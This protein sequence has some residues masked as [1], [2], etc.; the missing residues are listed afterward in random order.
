MPRPQTYEDLQQRID[1]LEREIR[2][3]GRSETSLRQSR[4][5]L[6]RFTGNM[7]ESLMVIDTDFVI[8]DVNGRFLEE[9]GGIPEEVL[10]QACHEITQCMENPC[11]QAGV[12]CP[13]KETFVS[14]ETKRMERIDQAADGKEWTQELLAFPLFGEEGNVDHVVVVNH[15]ITDRKREKQESIERE[16]LEGVLEM[17]G[18]VCLEL[19]Q[20]LQALSLYCERLEKAISEDNLLYDQIRWIVDKIDKM[21]DITRKLQSIATYQTK[22]YVEGKKIV[23]IDKASRPS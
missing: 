8:Q 17:A 7:F 3:H 1:A 16:R 11:C 20:P 5:C 19:N 13:A 14:G 4:R 9:H 21:T 22:D 12:P 2:Q 18:A 10:G 6:D 23:D 15:N